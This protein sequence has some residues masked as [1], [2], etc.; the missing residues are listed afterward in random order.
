[1]RRLNNL[2]VIGRMVFFVLLMAAL[3][4]SA[5]QSQA[6]QRL[7][8]IP[9][10]TEDAVDELA[11][12]GFFKVVPVVNQ[13]ARGHESV[14]VAPFRITEEGQIQRWTAS[15]WATVSNLPSRAT[16]LAAVNESTVYVGTEALGVF[17]STD[18]G[19][20]WN[21][22]NNTALG[23]VPG[24]VLDV[25]ALTVDPDDA[26]HVFAATAYLF[27]ST[28]V[29]RTPAG[30]YESTD[31]GAT[32]HALTEGRLPGTVTELKLDPDTPGLLIA[33][34]EAEGNLHLGLT[35]N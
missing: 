27:S 12:E 26:D 16:A 28:Q 10:S 32:W 23:L 22:V 17:K 31:G 1:M 5:V 18:A 14:S 19:N 24:S 35:A 9:A 33:H 34:W 2:S 6:S 20:T 13:P 15:A 21:E 3:A 29:K 25:T 8:D 30:I 7:T 11:R 4:F